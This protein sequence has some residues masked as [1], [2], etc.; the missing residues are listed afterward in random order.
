M[1]PMETALQLN[2]WDEMFDGSRQLEDSDMCLRLTAF[3]QNMVYERRA[4]VIEYEV[5]A[6]DERVV[7]ENA[8]N[9]IKC[10]GAYSSFAWRQ[11]R[12][13]ANALVN[14]EAIKA[15]FWKNCRRLK[16]KDICTPYMSVCTNLGEPELLDTVYNDPRLV[17]NIDVMRRELNWD[18]ALDFTTLKGM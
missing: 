9:S 7:V 8:N 2:G 1:I 11:G 13:A 5:G 18:N 12:V 10:N 15:M 6:Y 17:F 3:G 14:Q 4:T 16:S